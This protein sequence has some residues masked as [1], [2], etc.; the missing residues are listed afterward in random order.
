LLALA[1]ASATAAPAL[2]QPGDWGVTRDPFD[3]T[4]V[5]RYKGILAKNPHDASALAKLLEMYRRYK[6]VDLLK[7]EYQKT[8]DKDA[9]NWPALVVMGR[10]HRTIG[11][12]Q[13][14]RDLL[15]KAVG[16]K[17][18][19]AQTWILIGEID[20]AGG[21]NKEARAAYDK[22]LSHASAKEMKKKALRALADLAL[23]TGDNDAANTY[24]KSFL[25]LDPTRRFA[26]IRSMTMT[27]VVDLGSARP[28]IEVDTNQH[29][30][31]Y[32]ALVTG[33][34]PTLVG[35]DHKGQVFALADG[36]A[37][38]LLELV[39]RLLQLHLRLPGGGQIAGDP[40]KP[41]TAISQADEVH[42][43]AAVQ[44]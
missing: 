22:A 37:R 39:M 35:I 4:V 1:L 20:K 42:D 13:R 36:A 41:Q 19:D 17:D 23:A 21:K 8:L 44:A 15:V 40:R 33:E 29:R 31:M 7:E 25:E 24:F 28:I 26:L 10:L 16:V 32:S 14:A 30:L 6:T 11:D 43:A 5:A 38:P 2:A 12:D 18:S 9:S 3:K 27:R 34:R